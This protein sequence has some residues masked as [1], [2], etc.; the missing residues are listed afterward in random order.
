MANT[1]DVNNSC[2]KALKINK[3]C[4]K[5]TYI[6]TVYLIARIKIHITGIVIYQITI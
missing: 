5:Y 6:L 3:T 4:D 2:A 1:Y